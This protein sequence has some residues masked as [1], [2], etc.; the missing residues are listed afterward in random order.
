MGLLI[1]WGL[2]KLQFPAGFE[3]YLIV[4][5]KHWVFPVRELSE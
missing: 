4:A 2:K 5:D 1:F 3:T